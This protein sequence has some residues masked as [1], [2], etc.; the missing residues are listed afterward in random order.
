M[1]VTI[2][3]VGPAGGG[4]A[5]TVTTSPLTWTHT[6]LAGDTALYVGVITGLGGTADSSFTVTATYNG[7]AMTAMSPGQS[8]N[9][10]ALTGSSGF[11]KV[12]KLASPPTGSAFTVSVSVSPGT[13]MAIAGGSV[14]VAGSVTES[15]LT[16]ATTL[17][18]SAASGT[19]NVTG[20]TS[21]NQVLLFVGDGSGAEA[22]TGGATL[23]YLNDQTSS[24]GCGNTFCSSLASPGGTA[25]MSWTQTSDQYAAIAFE[26]QAAGAAAPAPPAPRAAPVPPGL[27][28]P[29]ALQLS[30]Q[31]PR[32]AVTTAP[33][34]SV[35]QRGVLVGTG[36]SLS[37]GTEA[38]NTLIVYVISNTATQP[39]VTYSGA[40]SGTA[41]CG[42]WSAG[43]NG[44]FAGIYY[45]L[46]T[47]LGITAVSYAG[48]Y[49]GYYREVNGIVA[50]PMVYWNFGGNATAGTTF[51]VGVSGYS[52]AGDFMTN[53]LAYDVSN[54]GS[55][56][57]DGWTDTRAATSFGQTSYS[58]AI[59]AA[60]GNLPSSGTYDCCTLDFKTVNQSGPWTA[61]GTMA[62]QY[63]SSGQ[64]SLLFSALNAG[65]LIVVY[66]KVS[67]PTISVS[68]VSAPGTTGWTQIL[69]NYTD[70]ASTPHTH[71]AWMG[72]VTSPGSNTLAFTFS[73][74]IGATFVE[75]CAQEF[76]VGN[77]SATYALDSSN[78]KSTTSTNN[79]PTW[80][81][82]AATAT[83]TGELFVGFARVPAG[84][85]INLPSG[86]AV[87]QIDPN[88]NP[89]MYALNIVGSGWNPQCWAATAA[90]CFAS[91]V[92]ISYSIPAVPPALAGSASFPA[93]AIRADSVI[94]PATLAVTASFPAPSVSVSTAPV[95]ITSSYE[96]GTTGTAIATAGSGTL[97]DTAWDFASAGTGATENYDSTHVHAGK[98]AAAYTT[99]ATSTTAHNGWG[100]AIGGPASN[101][102]Y[103][104]RLYLYLTALPTLNTR[105]LTIF[106][107]APATSQHAYLRVNNGGNLCFA[108]TTGT[109]LWLSAAVLPT[110]QWMRIEG[111]VYGDPAR[112]QAT[113]RLWTA[114]GADSPG[115]PDDSYAS[116]A[117]LN[118]V[119]PH[120]AVSFGVGANTA[121][122]VTYWL[123]DVGVSNVTWLG[124]AAIIPATLSV[125]ASF[126]VPTVSAGS[127]VTPATLATTASFPAPSLRCDA[128]FT[129]PV[130]ATSAS[131]PALT[132]NAGSGVTPAVLA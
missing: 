20:T 31:T 78:T 22:V 114:S 68:G 66:A 116:T 84:G 24:F 97:A 128:I 42:Y 87:I 62:S 11:V 80:P 109:Q 59:A 72:V 113:I 12:F 19:V 90:Q 71:N 99:A 96:A 132:V 25:V 67:S 91:G 98:M 13:F 55:P 14:S 120:G 81:T 1:A 36:G 57:A 49:G 105:I 21:G 60:A 110:G 2:S 130:L 88:S 33:G 107:T 119:G 54:G 28:S 121:S 69:P 9:G 46:N 37:K 100:A 129:P 61:V 38:G 93:P 34:Y 56:V 35:I 53:M 95:T 8:T 50:N 29:A 10:T 123:D 83:S 27:R 18:A 79:F 70:T 112:G 106:G 4:G 65:D 115:A 26:V 17:G 124:P 23:R 16:V 73:A 15:A 101:T 44:D 41:T 58:T 52:V 86:P 108:D 32:A 85:A 117:T 48:A 6:C 89:F 74:A 47:P 63:V 45:V 92:L 82:M 3:A 104:F 102:Q 51:S 75:V 122:V 5:G 126:P 127:G 40:A 131:F 30:G 64:G 7:I 39:V 111:W 125:P 77:P 118:T 103:W 43:H 76:S 94:T